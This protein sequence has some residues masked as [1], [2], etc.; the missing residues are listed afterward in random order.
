MRI[1]ACIILLKL[2]SFI[3]MGW[4]IIAALC[5]MEALYYW[6]RYMWNSLHEKRDEDETP[7]TPPLG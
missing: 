5:I 4:H 7:L 2:L 6:L 1:L 3:A